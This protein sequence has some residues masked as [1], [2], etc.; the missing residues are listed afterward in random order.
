MGNNI[1]NKS[2]YQ[3]GADD[4]L[5]FGIYLSVTIMLCFTTVS[6]SPILCY[7]ALIMILGVPGLIYF[8]LKRSYLADGATTQFSS[9]WLQGICI[10]FFGSI[11]MALTVYI[12]LRFVNPAYFANAINLLIEMYDEAGVSDNTY[13][14]LTQ[15][16]KQNAIPT[17]GATAVELISPTVLSGSLLSLIISFIIR[18]FSKK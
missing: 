12:Y 16:Q 7:P 2:V 15:I 18:T 4:G 13:S 1:K 8:F 11:L 10:F 9:L 3:R 5:W 17:A 6:S 14:L